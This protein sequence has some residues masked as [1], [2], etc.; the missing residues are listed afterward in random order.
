MRRYKV[1]ELAKYFGVSENT[2]FLW[3]SQGRFMDI[4]IITPVAISIDENVMWRAQTDELISV[5][6]VVRM[7]CEEHGQHQKINRDDEL[8]IL[9]D[10][11]AFFEKKY[12][13][14]YK[15]T[16]YL[17]EKLNEL[18]KRDNDEWKYLLKRHGENKYKHS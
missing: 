7:W 2:I 10:E 8:D 1:Q 6:D 15:K 14:P 3:I 12:G 9:S 16:L 18:E 5:T 17:K 11:I 4:K 13:G